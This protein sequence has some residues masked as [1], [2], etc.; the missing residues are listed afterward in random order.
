MKRFYV[1]GRLVE[2]IAP[3]IYRGA[4]GVCHLVIDELLTENGYADTP[5]NREMM[6]AAARELLAQQ[7]P[8]VV[9]EVFD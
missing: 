3:G 1:R 6:L 7:N 2:R 5:E 9:L 4:G 8:P